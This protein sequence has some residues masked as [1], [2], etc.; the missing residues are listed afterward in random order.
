MC[1]LDLT[2]N[3]QE[4]SVSVELSEADFSDEALREQAI[5]KLFADMSADDLERPHISALRAALNI[6]L[7]LIAAAGL[8]C[9]LFFSL[10]EYRL[11][12]SLSVS[13]GLLGL[14]IIVRLRAILIWTIKVYQ[15]FAPAE[16]RRRCVFTPTC[17]QYAIL[18]LQRY[19]VVRGVPKIISRLRRCHL[20]NGGEDPLK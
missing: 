17:S 13:L 19:G 2:D 3:T 14:Y 4:Q 9:A 20:P 12:V 7:P 11:A 16:V 15:R 18:A 5:K 10:S 8:F 6:I 1:E